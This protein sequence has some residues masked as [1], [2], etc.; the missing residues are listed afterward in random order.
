MSLAP[1]LAPE[2]SQR[3]VRRGGLYESTSNTAPEF[4]LKGLNQFPEVFCILLPCFQRSASKY[5]EHLVFG[6]LLT[7]GE[8][9]RHG[10]LEG[11]DEPGVY[12]VRGGRQVRWA[13]AGRARHNACNAI[14]RTLGGGGAL[15]CQPNP[16]HVSSPLFNPHIQPARDQDRNAF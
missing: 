12:S 9:L 13:E 14:L 3:A 2:Y 15:Y 5:A 6:C 7:V 11:P 10:G 4:C 16:L 1:C 8:G